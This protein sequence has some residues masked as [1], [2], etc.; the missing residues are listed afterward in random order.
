MTAG[1]S[2]CTPSL[3]RQMVQFAVFRKESIALSYQWL[4]GEPT[5]MTLALA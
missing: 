2:S 4:P 3:P 5:R 1:L